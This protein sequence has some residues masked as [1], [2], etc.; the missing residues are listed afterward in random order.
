[1]NGYRPDSERAEVRALQRHAPQAGAHTRRD[2]T[3]H[4]LASVRRVSHSRTCLNCSSHDAAAVLL[5]CE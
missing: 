5:A 4:F 2:E 3:A 1:M